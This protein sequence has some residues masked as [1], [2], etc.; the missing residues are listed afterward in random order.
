MKINLEIACEILLLLACILSAFGFVFIITE[1]WRMGASAMS[2][3]AAFF[4]TREVLRH[5]KAIGR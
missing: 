1:Q 5:Q 2:L 4:W 3:V